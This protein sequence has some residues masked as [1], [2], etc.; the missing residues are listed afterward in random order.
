MRL[1]HLLGNF[2][3]SNNNNNNNNIIIIIIII[4][5]NQDKLSLFINSLTGYYQN[6]NSHLYRE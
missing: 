1:A 3:E 2:L 6:I 4:I 5:K